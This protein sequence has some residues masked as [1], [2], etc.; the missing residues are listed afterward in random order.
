M[1][2]SATREFLLDGRIL[3]AG[4]RRPVT[5]QLAVGDGRVVPVVSHGAPRVRLPPGTVAVPGF[6]DPHLHLAA[7]AAARLSVDLAG[8]R[9]VA[10]VLDRLDA[11]ARR[12]RAGAWIR[13]RGYDPWRLAEGRS[14]T[15]TDLD[16]V[17]R[18]H[19]VTIHD[20]TGHEVVCNS[21][22]LSRLGLERP[23]CAPRGVEL[24]AGRP[25]G[26]LYDADHLLKAVKRLPLDALDD[27]AR[28]VSAD[29]VRAGVTAVTDATHT[30]GSA[31]FDLLGRW[32][33]AGLVRQRIEVMIGAEQLG[34]VVAGGAR[35]GD[36]VSGLTVGHVKI[37]P[38]ALV[39]DD[40]RQAV[41]RARRHGFPVAIH[42]LDIASLAEALE[43]LAQAPPPKLG[44]D[45]LEHVALALDEQVDLIAR[46]GAYVV[47]QPALVHH[48]RELYRRELSA[49]ERGWL[50]RAGSLLAAGVRVAASSD[51]PVV[52]VTPLETVRAAAERQPGE[53]VTWDEALAMVTVAAG[54][55]GAASAGT[56][57]P[58]ARAD[59][60]VLD[61]EP[62]AGP[63]NP[64]VL[65]TVID[66]QVVF[67]PE[68][69]FAAL[70]SLV[71]PA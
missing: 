3:T 6:V 44:R 13:G 33:R 56:L 15:R 68:G 30:N 69:C 51:A 19:P 21:T 43:V 29:L 62:G 46:S 10:D 38:E 34:A 7:M 8:A 5:D 9:S 40:L 20:A 4:S 52:D 39:I 14:P 58:G 16:R 42:T 24:D 31:A 47:T 26:R 37:V 48:R 11:K 28:A 45:R 1:D 53:R 17:A 59:L 60:V 18:G 61:R 50:Y 70:G 22:A 57:T 63:A 23:G 71:A 64:A 55:V 66:G 41:T 35:F 32:R 27:A 65:A 2:D 49:V 36:T 25:T 54:R 12:T 67:D